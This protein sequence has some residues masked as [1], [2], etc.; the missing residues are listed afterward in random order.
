[1]KIRPDG[2]KGRNMGPAHRLSEP[3]CLNKRGQHEHTGWRGSGVKMGMGANF[4][5][6][7]WGGRRAL[8]RDQ[9]LFRDHAFSRPPRCFRWHDGS[10]SRALTV[11]YVRLYIQ[12][13]AA[14]I[15][16]QSL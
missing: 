15:R 10:Q 3:S 11:L 6:A 14:L 1:M 8:P 12:T 2:G 7:S 16:F 13:K 5:S 4:S 9:M